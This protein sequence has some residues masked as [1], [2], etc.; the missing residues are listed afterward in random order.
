MDVPEAFDTFACGNCARSGILPN[1]TTILD[2]RGNRFCTYECAWSFRRACALRKGVEEQPG[3]T[4]N[5]R[6]LKERITADE[7]TRRNRLEQANT[8]R[9]EQLRRERRAK[10]RR[11]KEEEL[12]RANHH[13]ANGN[14]SNK[15]INGE[16]RSTLPLSFPFPPPADVP[17]E[18]DAVQEQQHHHALFLFTSDLLGED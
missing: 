3:A 12:C 2:E 15:N 6:R 18:E 16:R 11:Q 13:H 8:Q 4:R 9:V 10:R 14:I 7:Q 1:A 5:T 17:K